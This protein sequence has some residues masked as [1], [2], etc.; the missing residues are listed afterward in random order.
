MKILITGA[1]GFIGQHLCRKLIQEGHKV[2]ALTRQANP[3]PSNLKVDWLE[4]DFSESQAFKNFPEK[5]DS[6]IHLAQSN[7]Y[8]SPEG[9][10]D[11]MDVNV[12]STF[13][14]L[15]YAKKIKI[16]QFIYT[17]SGGIYGFSEEEAFSEQQN[18]PPPHTLGF[19]FSTKYISEILLNNYKPFFKS[20]ILRIFFAYGENQSSEKLIPSLISKVKNEEPILLEGTEGLTINPIYVEDVVEI[21]LNVLEKNENMVINVAGSENLSLRTIGNKIGKLIGKTPIFHEDK[22]QTSRKL[23]G[24]IDSLAKYLGYIP[25]INFE[26]GLKKTIENI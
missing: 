20:T 22:H 1:T 16:D 10:Q 15:E 12:M 8:K 5:L 24:K 13:L 4:W 7:N 6:I 25:K 2:Y 9:F 3:K 21:I 14:L 18:L 19:Y 17:S 11:M 26:L 23:I